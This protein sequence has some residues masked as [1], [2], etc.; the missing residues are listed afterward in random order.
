MNASTFR[1]SQSDCHDPTKSAVVTRTTH[2]L[3]GAQGIIK[4]NYT[5]LATLLTQPR[6]E[7]ERI[8]SYYEVMNVSDFHLHLMRSSFIIIA[9]GKLK[10]KFIKRY[11]KI[12]K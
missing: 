11:L 10:L 7:R 5:H 8:L 6:T 4:F 2:C 3:W 1:M 12:I 9:N